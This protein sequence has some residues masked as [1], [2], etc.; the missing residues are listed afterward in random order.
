MPYS[1]WDSKTGNSSYELAYSKMLCHLDVEIGHRL[2]WNRTHKEVQSVTFNDLFLFILAGVILL[3]YHS[4]TNAFLGT[5]PAIQ[6]LNPI[7]LVYI[8]IYLNAKHN[9]IILQPPSKEFKWQTFIKI[10]LKTTWYSGPNYELQILC[11]I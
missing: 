8:Y 5:E 9:N 11:P 2:L 3:V 6:L 4:E 10:R 7:P 1:V